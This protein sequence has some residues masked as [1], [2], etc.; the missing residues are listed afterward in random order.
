MAIQARVNFSNLI[1]RPR[2]SASMG[3]SSFAWRLRIYTDVH[4]TFHLDDVHT[5]M[6]RTAEPVKSNG[7]IR[8]GVRLTNCT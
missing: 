6:H 8:L 5:H 4:R 2:L 7:E 1:G 3:A